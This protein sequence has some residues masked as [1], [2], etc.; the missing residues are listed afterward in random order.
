VVAA[1][2]ID[3]RKVGKA[4]SEAIFSLPN[5]TTVFCKKVPKTETIVR[6]GRILDGFSEHMLDY[7]EKYVFVVSDEPEPD[8]DD[9]VRVLKQ[10]GA[11]I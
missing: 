2:D 5:N 8:R 6:M 1:F 7:D 11:E 9:V 10:S 3:K 4:V